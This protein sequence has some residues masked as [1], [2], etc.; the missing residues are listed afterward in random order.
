MNDVTQLVLTLGLVGIL[1]FLVLFLPLLYLASGAMMP[2]LQGLAA[3]R[4]ANAP[5]T[6]VP[7]APPARRTAAQR[8]PSK[9]LAV[10][11]GSTKGASKPAPKKKAA[12][13]SPAAK[14]KAA[15]K[16]KAKSPAKTKPARAKRL[17][18]PL[19]VK[20]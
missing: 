4:A 3:Q 19:C 1:A 5:A 9:K 15:T 8:K 16:A 2:W 10:G 12:K 7:S 20:V 14:K 11:P 6:T 17:R 18:W 13:K